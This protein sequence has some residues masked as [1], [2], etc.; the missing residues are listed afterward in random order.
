MADYLSLILQFVSNG[1]CSYPV[2]IK[3]VVPQRSLIEPVLYLVFHY[4]V[5]KGTSVKTRL[6]VDKC[7]CDIQGN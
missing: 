6:Y 3:S 5:V 7:V 2:P 4:N 1:S